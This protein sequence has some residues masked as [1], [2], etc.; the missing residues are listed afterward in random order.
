MQLLYQE[1][2]MK[3]V[4]PLEIW[5]SSQNLVSPAANSAGF[6]ER[7]ISWSISKFNILHILLVIIVVENNI[8]RLFLGPSV[9]FPGRVPKSQ[10]L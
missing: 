3:K 8:L 7:S 4:M 1:G 2:A 10:D 6:F 9:R 5:G